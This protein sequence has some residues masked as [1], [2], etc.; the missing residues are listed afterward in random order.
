MVTKMTQ[1]GHGMFSQ[2][3]GP[4]DRCRCQ[5][6]IIDEATKC[7]LARAT[8]FLKKERYK[9]VVDKVTPNQQKYS[10]VDKVMKHLEYSHGRKSSKE[11]ILT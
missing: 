4:C 5:A 10:F 2:S 8:R 7:K 3:A 1:L 11:N 6:R 9:G